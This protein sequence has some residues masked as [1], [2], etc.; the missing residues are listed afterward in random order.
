MTSPFGR[1]VG[2]ALCLAVFA[3]GCS[4]GKARRDDVSVGEG[5]PQEADTAESSDPTLPTQA[6]DPAPGTAQEAEGAPTAPPPAAPPK[7]ANQG[8]R[9]Y[10][11]G[12]KLTLTVNG[13]LNYKHREDI[14]LEVVARNDGKQPLQYDPNDLRHFAIIPA[15]GAK[16][17]TW[18]DTDCRPKPADVVGGAITLEPGEE[19]VFQTTYP[20]PG[21]DGSNEGCRL[22]PGDYD[23]GGLV[24]WC[25]PGTVQADGT[26][27]P[28]RRDIV[29]SGA[30]RIKITA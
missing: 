22:D 23:V 6:G 20:G 15:G 7:P 12:W 29:A 13:Q 5:L 9:S 19:A 26:C 2:L 17:R 27:D 3:S 28:A 18:Y 16:G 21:V 25:P 4:Y 24:A 14:L 10:P 11:S 1:F 30:V 8:I